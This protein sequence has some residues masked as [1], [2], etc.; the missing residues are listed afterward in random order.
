M[1]VHT[2]S[3]P[4]CG[5]AANNRCSACHRARYCCQEHQVLDRRRHRAMCQAIV[6]SDKDCQVCGNINRLLRLDSE[7]KTH[8]ATVLHVTKTTN[9][10]KL[11]EDFLDWE[12]LLALVGHR[13]DVPPVMRHLMSEQLKK[14]PESQIVIIV[15][16]TERSV[17][18]PALGNASLNWTTLP[19]PVKRI[20]LLELKRGTDE[21]SACKRTMPEICCTQ[22]GGT[23][24]LCC[25]AR[26]ILSDGEAAFRKMIALT[27]ATYVLF[28]C[29]SCGFDGS[30]ISQAFTKTPRDDN[31]SD[32]VLQAMRQF[33]IRM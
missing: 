28:K 23:L 6:K 20:F 11:L 5:T 29:P 8:G 19:S 25:L 7:L 16:K 30:I 17:S 4:G 27:L 10:D 9:T 18:Y 3:K 2:C 32:G 31:T 26:M 22:C 21:C 12:I 13:G 1:T 15:P 14:N 24:C 33:A